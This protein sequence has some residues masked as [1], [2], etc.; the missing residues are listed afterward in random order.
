MIQVEKE[1]RQHLLERMRDEKEK[2]Q[3]EVE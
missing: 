1:E 3:R 2:L